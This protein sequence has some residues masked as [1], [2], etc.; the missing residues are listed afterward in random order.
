MEIKKIGGGRTLDLW[1]WHLWRCFFQI[2]D[3]PTRVVGKGA[4]STRFPVM[5]ILLWWMAPL[6]VV[7]SFPYVSYLKFTRHGDRTPGLSRKKEPVNPPERQVLPH[8]AKRIGTGIWFHVYLYLMLVQYDKQAAIY[9]NT[10]CF[11]WFITCTGSVF[12]FDWVKGTLYSKWWH[13]LL[14]L[15][16]VERK[17]NLLFSWIV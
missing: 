9:L 3:V 6:Y 10:T 5:E 11:L 1:L 17:W 16:I 8:N 7:V 4:R 12:C 15:D 13:Y 14:W 2:N